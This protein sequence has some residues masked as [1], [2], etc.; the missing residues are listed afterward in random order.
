MNMTGLCPTEM[1]RVG[2]R[3]SSLAGLGFSGC[4]RVLFVTFVTAF[5]HPPSATTEL[6]LDPSVV[7]G[8]GSALL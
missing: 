2:R 5:S 8:I 3:G 7:G 6:Y 4:E 1:K